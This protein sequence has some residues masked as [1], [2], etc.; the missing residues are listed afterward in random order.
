MNDHKIREATEIQNLQV[1]DGNVGVGS[2][3]PLY[4]LLPRYFVCSSV[5]T[6]VFSIEFELNVLI[7]FEDRTS[8]TENFPI[9]LYRSTRQ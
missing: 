5:V 3:I 2:V 1:V 9:R 6:G 4:M 8:L 7:V